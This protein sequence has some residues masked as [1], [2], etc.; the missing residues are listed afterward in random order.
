MLRTPLPRPNR[1]SAA[2]RAASS[3]PAHRRLGVAHDVV[4]QQLDVDLLL[5]LQIEP[6][7]AFPLPAHLRFDGEL[8]G[9]AH[10]AKRFVRRRLLDVDRE[11]EGRRRRQ[12]AEPDVAEV[13]LAAERDEQHHVRP[14]A[15]LAGGRSQTTRA[16]SAV[17]SNPSTREHM[18]EQQVLLEAVAAAAALHELA[19]ERSEIEH[20]GRPASVSRFSN[21]MACG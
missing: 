17:T 14:R 15:H 13:A 9:Y 12:A 6:I 21:G 3:R 18:L 7:E 5:L 2:T 16:A 10:D 4:I 11:L 19:L 1:R 20:M 8:A